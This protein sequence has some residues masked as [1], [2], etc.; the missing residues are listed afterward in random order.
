MF[1]KLLL[2]SILVLSAFS[3]PAYASDPCASLLCLAG[4]LQGQAGGDSC[5]VPISDYFGIVVYGRHD[6]FNASGTSSARNSYIGQCNDGGTN[7]SVKNDI[8]SAYGALQ[9]SPF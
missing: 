7:Q 5:S 1:S 8:S 2:L 4:K 6:K 9:Y 3:M